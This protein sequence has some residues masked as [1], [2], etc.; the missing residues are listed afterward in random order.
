MKAGVLDTQRA[1]AGGVARLEAQTAVLLSGYVPDIRRLSVVLME[2]RI[3]TVKRGN[4][5]RILAEFSHAFGAELD[6]GFKWQNLAPGETIVSSNWQA[7]SSGVTLSNPYNANGV[8]TVVVS[9]LTL[10]LV[11]RLVNTIATS[12]GRTDTRVLIISCNRR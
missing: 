10:G 9:G 4:M 1:S 5:A 6:Y 2:S 7:L 12:G 8:T 3:T 11:Y